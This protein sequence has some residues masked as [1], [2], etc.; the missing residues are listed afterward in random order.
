ML[1]P[2]PTA[3][4]QLSGKISKEP[5]K[6]S[7]RYECQLLR[8]ANT[9]WRNHGMTTDDV[10]LMFT[11]ALKIAPGFPIHVEKWDTMKAN[12]AVLVLLRPL[13]NVGTQ[14]FGMWGMYNLAKAYRSIKNPLPIAESRTVKPAMVTLKTQLDCS[15]VHDTALWANIFV[16]THLGCGTD[17][18]SKCL[19]RSHKYSKD[20]KAM[21][22]KRILKIS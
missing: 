13:P 6:Q 20:A 10:C 4:Q 15:T 19:C 7:K 18:V 12:H 14:N 5:G 17:S 1:V 9:V 2:C 11:W 16:R 3:P 8:K 21:Q 22:I